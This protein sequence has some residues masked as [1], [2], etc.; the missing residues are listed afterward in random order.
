MEDMHPIPPTQ[1]NPDVRISDRAKV[2][3]IPIIADN[4]SSKGIY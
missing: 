1:S 4:T 2:L 3:R